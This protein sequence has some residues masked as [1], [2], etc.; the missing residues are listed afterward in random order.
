MYIEGLLSYIKGCSLLAV[1]ES[2]LQD[3][4]TLL[5]QESQNP[6]VYTKLSCFLPWIADQYNMEY[7][8]TGAAAEE[9]CSSGT[10]DMTDVATDDCRCSC[11]GESKCIFPFYWNGK[12]YEQCHM[13]EEDK[14]ILPVFRCPTANT[15]NKINGINSFTYSDLILQVC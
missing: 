9:E 3:G 2:V 14:F 10:G 8:S 13:L 12:L 11:P 5:Y 6:N 7:D 15:I 1:S 4:A